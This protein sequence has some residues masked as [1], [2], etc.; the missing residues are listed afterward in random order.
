MKT[1]IP[2]Y[3]N[4]KQWIAAMADAGLLFHFDDDPQD[5]VNEHGER[6]FTED[7]STEVRA[8]VARLFLDTDGD[9]F[10][11]VL[12]ELESREAS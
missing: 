9:P 7:E 2:T 1:R 4:P 6:L 8:T 5:I 3:E 10:E 11:L 12:S